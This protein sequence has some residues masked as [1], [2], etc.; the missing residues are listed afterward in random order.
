V[1]RVPGYTTEM[2]SGPSIFMCVAT[3][4]RFLGVKVYYSNSISITNFVWTFIHNCRFENVFPPTLALKSNRIFIWYLGNLLN[5]FQ[6]LVEAV[7][8]MHFTFCWVMNV[9]T[10]DMSPAIS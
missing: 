9:Q 6:F 4:K 1:V 2:Y 8:H 10:N 5:T 3:W 7:L